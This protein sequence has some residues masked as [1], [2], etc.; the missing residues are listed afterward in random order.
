[1][2]S[3]DIFSVTDL[4]KQPTTI[5]ERSHKHPQFIFRNNKMVGVIISPSDYDAIFSKAP[6]V[7]FHEIRYD[8]MTD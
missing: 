8:E 4:R 7:E 1:M 6:T 2:E 5:L 3:T